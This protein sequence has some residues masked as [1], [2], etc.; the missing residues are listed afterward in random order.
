MCRAV[1]EL[2]HSWQQE[3]PAEKEHCAPTTVSNC[4]SQS[5]INE[6]KSVQY[7]KK[8]P[9]SAGKAGFCMNLEIFQVPSDFKKQNHLGMR[10]LCSQVYRSSMLAIAS[11]HV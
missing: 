8:L 3:S 6:H 10:S 7:Y 9:T 4:P 11:G 5:P 1:V 2:D